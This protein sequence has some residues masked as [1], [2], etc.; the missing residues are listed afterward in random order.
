MTASH[1][2][3]NRSRSTTVGSV[4]AMAIHEPGRS[5]RETCRRWSNEIGNR[6]PVGDAD[7]S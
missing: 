6:R 4:K 2:A 7:T 3:D 1:A 5:P